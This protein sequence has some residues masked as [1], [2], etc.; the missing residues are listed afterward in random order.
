VCIGF[1]RIKKLLLNSLSFEELWFSKAW[2]LGFL[3]RDFEVTYPPFSKGLIVVVCLF[4]LNYSP[5]ARR[6]R[7]CENFRGVEKVRV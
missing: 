4:F 7:G 5:F 6:Y 2:L 3:F 1:K